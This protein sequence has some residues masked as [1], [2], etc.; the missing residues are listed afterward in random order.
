MKVVRG[1][2]LR[3][4]PA[5]EESFVVV[6]HPHELCEYPPGSADWRRES[7]HR[8]YNTEVQSLEIAA[9]SLVDFPDAP[10]ELRLQWARQAWD[11]ARHARLVARQLAAQGGRPGEFPVINYDWGVACALPTY[12]ARLAVQNRTVEAG[13][14]DLLRALR[15]SWEEAGDAD[16]AATMDGIL[17][18]EI[19]HV[20]FANEWVRRAAAADPRVLMQVGAAMAFLREVTAA[21][22]PPAGE[23]NA[24]GFEIAAFERSAFPINREDRRLAGFTDG[25]LDQLAAQDALPGGSGQ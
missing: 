7:L 23:R 21:F 16:T 15:D 14:M 11:E 24:S 5:R 17:A 10:W 8:H 2:T 19:Q 18:D 25:D 22:T 4:D 9:Q 3:A 1:V 6:Q 20:R 12:A 13:E